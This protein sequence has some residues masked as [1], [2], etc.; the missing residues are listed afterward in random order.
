MSKNNDSSI[1]ENIVDN[2]SWPI[3]VLKLKIDS[4]ILNAKTATKPL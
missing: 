1:K 4:E 3:Y 2:G